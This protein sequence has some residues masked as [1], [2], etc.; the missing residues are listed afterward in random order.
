MN[1]TL[2][3]VYI[4]ESGDLGA[5]CGTKW[6]VLT[7]AI[8]N[9][10]DE[11]QIRSTIRAIRTR[12]NLRMIHFRDVKDFNRRSFIVSELSGEN[13]QLV[14]VLFDTSRYDK[15]K[16]RSERMAY[17]FICELL[18]ERVSWVL[19]DTCRKGNIVLSSRGTSKDNELVEY[20]TDK[21]TPYHESRIADVFTGVE[22]KQAADWDMLQL[23]DVCATSMFYSHEINGYGFITPC[24]ALRLLPKL[25]RQIGSAGNYG[26][27]YFSDDMKPSS[28]L[29]KAHKICET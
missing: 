25:Y 11:P 19:K 24:F 20:I 18:L 12:L 22:Y 27:N 5:S 14:N 9:K 1:H 2:C 29:L 13:F 15:S 3:T 21:L 8:V 28:E 17:N 7:A 6:F 16:M 26:V 23:A 10:N 4:D